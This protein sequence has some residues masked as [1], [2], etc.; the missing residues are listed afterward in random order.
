MSA[1]DQVRLQHLLDA[2]RKAVEL[3]RGRVRA[4]LD[5]DEV[6]ALALVRLPEV[7]GEAAKGITEETRRAV[8]TPAF[9]GSNWPELAIASSTGPS[10]SIWTSCG[11]SS[12]R[13]CHRS[14]PR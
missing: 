13:I 5:R 12:P 7:L 11:R 2:A 14:W 6:L 3:S 1:G 4:D 9:H 10:T 8:H